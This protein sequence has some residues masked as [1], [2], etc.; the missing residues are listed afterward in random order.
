MKKQIQIIESLIANASKKNQLKV[1]SHLAHIC[2]AKM[3]GD[4]SEAEGIT[5]L[6]QLIVALQK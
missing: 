2:T 3:M 5:M 1:S 4:I 6:N